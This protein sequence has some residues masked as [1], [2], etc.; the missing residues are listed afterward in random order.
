MNL[1]TSKT[2][3]SLENKLKLL[4]FELLDLLLIFLYLSMSNLVFGQTSLKAPL[5]YVGSLVLA[6]TLYFAKRGKPDN[7]LQDKLSS[8]VSPNIFSA[9]LPDTKYQSYLKREI[10]EQAKFSYQKN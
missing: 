6:I 3:R 8:L 10:Y 5:V 1:F 4:G 7:Y 2:P 9:N